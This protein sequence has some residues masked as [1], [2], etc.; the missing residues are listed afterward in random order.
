M[1]QET[2]NNLPGIVE[3][4]LILILVGIVVTASLYI[5]GPW[6]KQQYIPVNP[7]V[8]MLTQRNYADVSKPISF[9]S[10]NV[11]KCGSEKVTYYETRALDPQG[12]RV[13]LGVCANATKMFSI[14]ILNK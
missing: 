7:V 2:E 6:I 4:M 11:E 12:N 9:P 5:A 13:D 8:N 14:T 10:Q 3:Y 1:G